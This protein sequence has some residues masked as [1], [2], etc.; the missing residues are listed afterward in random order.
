MSWHFS[1]DHEEIEIAM[2]KAL[3]NLGKRE[4]CISEKRS[5]CQS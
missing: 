5:D 3:I 2:S 4:R 1:A